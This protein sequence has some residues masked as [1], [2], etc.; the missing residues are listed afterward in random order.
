MRSLL[1]I[2]GLLC[3]SSAHADQFWGGF[4]GGALGGVAGNV[5]SNYMMRPQAPPVQYAPAP[6]Y[7]PVQQI[8]PVAYCM[9]RFRS[10]NPETG[11]FRGY[12]GQ[13]RRCP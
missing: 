10:Y 4:A 11:L 2:V 8:D 9:Q 1:I 5:I 13:Y 6:Q 12:D 3:A 7:A